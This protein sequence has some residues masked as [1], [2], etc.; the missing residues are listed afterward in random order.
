MEE[1]ACNGGADAS[2][3]KEWCKSNIHG[4]WGKMMMEACSNSSVSISHQRDSTCYNV[5]H[6]SSMGK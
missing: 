6:N 3:S 2:G 4:L 5:S 1:P